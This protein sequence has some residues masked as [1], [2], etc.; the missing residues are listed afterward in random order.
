MKS[1]ARWLGG[2]A[3][4][5][6]AGCTTA[7]REAA[8]DSAVAVISASPEQLLLG[9]HRAESIYNRW[10]DEDRAKFARRGSPLLAVRT[11]GLTPEQAASLAGKI[12][13][14][15]TAI[16]VVLWDARAEK[17]A[18]SECYIVIT[19]PPRGETARFSSHSARYVGSL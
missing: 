18:G 17:I 3:A 10:S 16:C 5:L 15:E 14:P 19:P 6:L 4:L 13:A 9:K 12:T 8:P 2:L 11:L 7:P 1:T